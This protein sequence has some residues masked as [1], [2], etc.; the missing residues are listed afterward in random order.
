[1]AMNEELWQDLNDLYTKFYQTQD[2]KE[3]IFILNSFIE[4]TTLFPKDI[5][6]NYLENKMLDF[7]GKHYEEYLKYREDI[8]QELNSFLINN[9][10]ISMR[11]VPLSKKIMQKS[12]FPKQDEK[13]LIAVL[14][15]FLDETSIHLSSFF[16]ELVSNNRL[17]IQNYNCYPEKFDINS[18]RYNGCAGILPLDE[19]KPY[20]Y[21]NGLNDFYD[22]YILIHEL[23][24]A[25]YNKINNVN[26]K[27]YYNCNQLVKNEIP[28]KLMEMLFI[29]F[30]I[31]K[32]YQE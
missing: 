31:R 16:E 11:L 20:I 30:L 13:C 4:I 8:Y 32:G 19:I 5:S 24:H 18:V 9:A 21:I 14:Y 29:R 15:E 26:Y 7:M 17:F 25:Y 12:V 27:D 3:K 10:G 22:L 23:G 6:L 28:S 2:L 1:M